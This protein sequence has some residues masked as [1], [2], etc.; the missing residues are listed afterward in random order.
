MEAILPTHTAYAD[1][2]YYTKERYRSVSILTFEKSKEGLIKDSYKSLIEESSIKEF[3]WSD[4]RQARD[5]FAAIKIID[6]TTDFARKNY[7]RMDVLI[8]DTYD[9]R[10]KI[11]SRDDIANLQRMYYHLFKHVLQNRWQKQSV[12]ELYP[13]ENSALN[14]VSVHDYLDIAS[15][16]MQ[17]HPSIFKK[18]S[19][20]IRLNRDF[21]IL[22]IQEVSSITEPLIQVTDLFAGIG[23]YSHSIFDKYNQWLSNENGQ[24]RLNFEMNYKL[25][26]T[27]NSERERFRVIKH[28]DDQCKKTKLGVSLNS[29][30]G[31]K[32]FDPKTPINFWVYQPQ[33][34]NDKAPTKK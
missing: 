27:S 12:W 1:E 11:P 10:H 4:L 26:K 14:W 7:L 6:Q 29:G 24:M 28:F 25:E 16:S 19:F 33:H 18:G 3:K 23:A 34:I 13:D 22:R 21:Q 20:S 2:S 15:L 17:I 32:T 30:K 31:F 9:S 5:R 8:W